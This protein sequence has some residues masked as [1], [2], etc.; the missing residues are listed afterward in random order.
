M[1]I[2]IYFGCEVFKESSK[3]SLNSLERQDFGHLCYFYDPYV[4]FLKNCFLKQ[5]NPQYAISYAL[6]SQ[7]FT[8]ILRSERNCSA[9][10]LLTPV[11]MNS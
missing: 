6:I 2:S 5:M 7:L 4:F 1:F 10:G 8:L 11:P 9:I 3:N